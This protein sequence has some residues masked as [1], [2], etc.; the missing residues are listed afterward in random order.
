MRRILPISFFAALLLAACETVVEVKLPPHEAQLVAHSLFGLDSLWFVNVSTTISSTGAQDPRLADEATVEIWE[1]ERLVERLS[2]IGRGIFTS[3]TNAP[4]PEKT[5]TLRVA[6]P[7]FAVSEGSGAV[8]LAARITA[9]EQHIEDQRIDEVYMLRTVRIKLTVDDPSGVQNYYG[10][11]VL[12]DRR[13]ID[14]ETGEI[15]VLPQSNLR[16]VTNDPSLG[17]QDIFE[18]EKTRHK[19]AIFNDDLFHGQRHTFDFEIEYA[20]NLRE[21]EVEVER[22]IRVVFMAVSEDYFLYRK[23][24]KLQNSVADNPFAEPVH[25]HSN[26][27]GGP[28]IFAGFR[29]EVFPLETDGSGN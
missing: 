11:Q 25:V 19:E 5:Y 26:M 13:L 15:H 9:F 22:S 7:G 28:G 14:K 3:A 23:T 27:T 24:V 21:R 16:F 18:S 2:P 6:A 8:P 10:L 20:I 4:A 12:Q 29:A 17:E 1:G